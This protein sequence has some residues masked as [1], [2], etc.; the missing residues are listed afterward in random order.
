[1]LREKTQLYV[2]KSDIKVRRIHSQTHFD[3]EKQTLKDSEIWQACF[4]WLRYE[5]KLEPCGKRWSHPYVA[6]VSPIYLNLLSENLKVCSNLPQKYN[7]GDK[8]N[9]IFVEKPVLSASGETEIEY[10]PADYTWVVKYGETSHSMEEVGRCIG[11][12]LSNLKEILDI[13]EIKD[14]KSEQNI[15]TVLQAFQKYSTLLPC[16]AWDPN[17]RMDPLGGA[18]DQVCLWDAEPFDPFKSGGHEKIGGNLIKDIRGKLKYY[19]EVL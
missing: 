10:Y 5:E 3:H 14:I 13:T 7:H 2:S 17:E 4:R 8:D 16:N 19:R 12:I 6:T 18:D 11:A 9:K 15:R 1:M